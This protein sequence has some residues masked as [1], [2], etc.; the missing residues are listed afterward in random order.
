MG[1][2]YPVFLAHVFV[3]LRK[4]AIPAA[5]SSGLDIGLSNLSL[6]MITLSFYSK[7]PAACT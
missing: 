6:K 7:H 3:A 5:V 1:M 4:K 2:F